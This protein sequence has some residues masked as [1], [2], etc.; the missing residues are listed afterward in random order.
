MEHLSKL[1]SYN[2]KIIQKKTMKTKAL[3]MLTLL[4]TF[5]AFSINSAKSQPKPLLY[6]CE[7]YDEAKGE[8]GQSSTFTTGSLCVMVKSSSP[9][10]LSA[11]TIQFDKYDAKTETF[12]KYKKLNFTIN[13][14]MEYVFFEN[15]ELKFDAPGV[16]R[17]YLLD[18]RGDVVAT[19]VVI[20]VSKK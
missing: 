20:I 13:A 9:M 5:C 2:Y 6:F 18:G 7:T 17:A 16:Y 3:F 11:V 12:S 10:G 1:N 14:D 4:L 19:A 15:E 8:V